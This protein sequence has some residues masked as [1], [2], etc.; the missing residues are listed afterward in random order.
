MN[1]KTLV[2]Q[3]STMVRK[4]SAESD[5]GIPLVA[6]DLADDRMVVRKVIPL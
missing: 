5:S 1:K 3:T 4:R 2:A 6:T